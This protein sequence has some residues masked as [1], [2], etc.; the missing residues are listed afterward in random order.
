L[1]DLLPARDPTCPRGK[2]P[3][4]G[5]RHGCVLGALSTMARTRLCRLLLANLK[6]GILTAPNDRRTLGVVLQFVDA[7]QSFGRRFA[8]PRRRM[9]SNSSFLRRGSPVGA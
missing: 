4:T 6:M 5:A 2:P 1:C 3:V 9:R 8:L 7:G